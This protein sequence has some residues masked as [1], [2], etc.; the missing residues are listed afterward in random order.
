MYKTSQQ[1]SI[2]TPYIIK[3][4]YFFLNFAF[5]NTGR[6]FS[7]LLPRMLPLESR[8]DSDVKS[9][10]VIA[11]GYVKDPEVTFMLKRFRGE[12][13]AARE[14]C[15]SS[16]LKRRKT[17]TILDADMKLKRLWHSTCERNFQYRL[18]GRL[19]HSPSMIH[20]HISDRL[21][22]C[23]VY[24]SRALGN[25]L[26]SHPYY[27]LLQAC[28]SRS[29]VKKQLANC[30]SRTQLPLDPSIDDTVAHWLIDWEPIVRILQWDKAFSNYDSVVSPQVNSST[31]SMLSNICHA[32]K[33]LAS[34]EHNRRLKQLHVY[35]K[36]NSSKSSVE[37]AYSCNWGKMIHLFDESQLLSLQRI[38]LDVW[39]ENRRSISGLLESDLFMSQFILEPMTSTLVDRRV[40]R[41]KLI[42]QYTTSLCCD[43]NA[44]VHPSKLNPVERILYGRTK[45]VTGT[46]G[47][48]RFLMFR[49]LISMVR[50]WVE[51]LVGLQGEKCDRDLQALFEDGCGKG[52]SVSILNDQTM[53]ANAALRIKDATMTTLTTVVNDCKEQDTRADPFNLETPVTDAINSLFN[54]MKNVGALRMLTQEQQRL[55]LADPSNLNSIRLIDDTLQLDVDSLAKIEEE[56]ESTVSIDSS[57]AVLRCLVFP[58]LHYSDLVQPI[59]K[60]W[61]RLAGCNLL[62]KSLYHSQFG[63]A[64]PRWSMGVKEHDWKLH[65]RYAL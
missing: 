10:N 27:Q 32:I 2:V 26:S 57:E 42:H 15:T 50:R 37:Q 4:S 12:T 8:S 39:M 64:P 33:K 61:T 38:I 52:C 56:A 36:V 23:F 21:T 63:A 34:R 30:F 47:H 25:W 44:M 53:H 43:I 7:E 24:E 60:L 14:D 48:T 54:V 41:K 11:S 5:R 18:D 55:H 45:F 58:Y 40:I 28:N 46:D 20:R 51:Y 49:I 6:P 16:Q 59:C 22:D 13:A 29:Q 3:N 31:R 17:T 62:W 65:V 9:N 19:S 35:Y 1:V